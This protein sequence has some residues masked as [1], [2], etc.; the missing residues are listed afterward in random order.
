MEDE[1]T[2]THY[3]GVFIAHHAPYILRDESGRQL[4]ALRYSF[5]VKGV[6]RFAETLEGAH[7]QIDESLGPEFPTV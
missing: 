7:R 4:F 6:Q 3:R 5:F 2:M 1:S